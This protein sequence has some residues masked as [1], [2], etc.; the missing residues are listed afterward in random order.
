M[1]RARSAAGLRPVRWCTKRPAI[2]TVATVMVVCLWITPALAVALAGVAPERYALTPGAAAQPISA[3][4]VASQ[5]PPQGYWLTASDGG[6][7][8]Y[9]GAAFK[10]S[11]GGLALTQPVVAMAATADG[12]G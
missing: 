9:G 3:R 2:R 1:I 8:N 5:S 6:I 7:F 4:S 10:G 12:G 11:A